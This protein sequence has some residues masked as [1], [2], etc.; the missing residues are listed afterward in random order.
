VS[1]RSCDVLILGGGLAGLTLALSLRKKRPELSVRVVERT[2]FPARER[3]HKVGE[4]TVELGATYFARDVGLRE[5]FEA[6]QLPKLGL[7]FFLRH[8]GEP[9]EERLEYGIFDT[10]NRPFLG[11]E[12]PSYQL[13]RGKLENHLAER[14]QREEVELS[15]GAK[16]EKVELDASRGHRVVLESGEVVRPRWVVDATGRRRWIARQLGLAEDAPHE[17]HAMWMR[18]TTVITPDDLSEDAAFRERI[19]I[20]NARR[21]STNH[22]CGPGYWAWL[23]PLAGGATSVG[24]V[25][26][27]EIAP[28]PAHADFESFVAWLAPREPEL[29]RVLATKKDALEDVRVLRARAYGMTRSFSRDRWA[30]TGEASWFLDPL[31]SPGSD[32]IAIGNTM[33]VNLIDADCAGRSLTGAAHAQQLAFREIAEGFVSVYRGSYRLLGAP[34]AMLRKIVWDSSSYFGTTL[35]LFRN[36]KLGDLAFLRAISAELKA[37]R[38]LQL[39]AQSALAKLAERA[40]TTSRRSLDQHDVPWMH[41]LYLRSEPSYDDRDLARVLSENVA[42]LA[43]E[44]SEIERAANGE[45]RGGW[46][47]RSGA[48]A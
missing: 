38:Q 45:R 10:P 15:Q 34:G 47:R 8:E 17:S 7:R 19:L 39:R 43:R 36:G 29:A 35:L 25:A 20:P 37:L 31:Y 23:I 1:E 11:L 40:P 33:T 3:A 24:I 16:V 44:V 22:L 2:V 26:D 6:E 30:A 42:T 9:L 14:V 21:Y 32:F 18:L 28:L 27:P 12:I 4:S 46:E 41:Q 48:V 13:D 5:H